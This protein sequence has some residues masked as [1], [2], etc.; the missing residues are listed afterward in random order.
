MALDPVTTILN[1]SSTIIDKLWPDPEQANKAKIKLMELQQTG[2]LAI[3]AAETD[4]A[5]GQMAINVIE[6]GSKKLFKSGWRPFIG[7]VCGCAF[8][9]H[10]LALPIINI[11]IVACGGVEIVLKFDMASLMSVLLGMLGLGGM[12]TYEKLKKVS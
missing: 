9:L 6:A 5:K 7:W 1:I 11:I 10:F 3:L 12:R 4:I 2:E 8:A